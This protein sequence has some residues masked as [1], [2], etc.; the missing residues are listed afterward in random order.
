MV[1][2]GRF[3]VIGDATLDVTVV[4][5]GPVRDGGDVPALIRTGPGG[6]GA[7]VAVRLARGGAAV[8][9]AAPIAPD[10]AGRLLAEALEGEGVRL[11]RIAA[12]RSSAVVVLLDASGERSMLSDRR[13]IRSSAIADALRDAAWVH[14]SA[15]ALI[16]AAEGDPLAR[17]LAG[18]PAGTRLSVAGG[19]VPPERGT[20]EGLRARLAVARPDLLAASRDE[21]AALLQEPV[22]PPA[23]ESA[24]RLRDLAPIVVVTAGADGSA[25]AAAGTLIAEPAM[26]GPWPLV[27][28][29]GSG[30]AYLAVL[31]SALAT[32]TWPPPADTLRRAMR[33][34][35]L[36]GLQAASGLGAQAEIVGE[37]RAPA[38]LPREV[39][40]TP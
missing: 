3:L 1:T 12:E 33:L 34:G 24:H 37:R 16:D 26:T 20:V 36:A 30:D 15:Y 14:V 40:G 11:H 19:S 7:N 25:A 2:E 18:R 39:D 38:S 35:S 21:A 29:T 8:T 5:S 28:A 9:L 10:A 23:A 27:D 13:P 4:P 32:A 22:P 6:Q 31:I 17:A